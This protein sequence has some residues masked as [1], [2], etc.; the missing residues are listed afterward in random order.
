MTVLGKDKFA[1]SD[2]PLTFKVISSDVSNSSY[3]T[4]L[5][6]QTDCT[7]IGINT[8]CTTTGGRRGGTVSHKTQ[9]AE[10]SDG[11][12]YVLECVSATQ[13]F[14]AGM[15]TANGGTAYLGCYV[16]PDTYRGR[17]DK[18]GHVQLIGH[19][20][21]GKPGRLTFV[22][23]SVRPKTIEPVEKLTVSTTASQKQTRAVLNLSDIPEQVFAST[24]ECNGIPRVRWLEKSQT[25]PY[26]FLVFIQN[27]HPTWYLST[28]DAPE[29]KVAGRDYVELGT[30]EKQAV[31][32]AC[33]LIA[34]GWKA[35]PQ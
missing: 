21:N 22:V 35:P 28:A 25:A 6:Y 31:K 4:N 30:D 19:K 15:A 11:N 18:H 5:P 9:T 14:L 1:P 3:T 32:V 23:L 29:E 12:I 7:T 20:A 16:Q 33:T 26:W 10:A 17:F 27:P 2:Y 13:G 24:P 34:G 8:D